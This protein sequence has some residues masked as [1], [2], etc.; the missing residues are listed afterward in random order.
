ME[1][2]DHI[3]QRLHVI[4]LALTM[5]AL[6]FDKLIADVCGMRNGLAAAAGGDRAVAHRRD[7]IA[8]ESS[9]SVE[10]NG[11]SHGRSRDSSADA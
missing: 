1:E 11:G 9:Q 10:L 4:E 5:H 8:C 3:K 7:Y 2:L 6:V